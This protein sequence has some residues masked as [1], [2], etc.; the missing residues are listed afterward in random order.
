MSSHCS[1]RPDSYANTTHSLLRYDIHKA[2]L[3]EDS[4]ERAYEGPRKFR[5]LGKTAECIGISLQCPQIS[6]KIHGPLSTHDPDE[7]SMSYLYVH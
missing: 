5:G 7:L 4:V 6:L 1:Y 2:E 3:D